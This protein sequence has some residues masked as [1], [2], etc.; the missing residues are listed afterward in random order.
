MQRQNIDIL[1]YCTCQHS[2]TMKADLLIE[3]LGEGCF[4]P[5]VADRMKCS[6]CGSKEIHSRPAYD[7]R[8]NN[9]MVPGPSKVPL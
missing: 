2:T 6:K 5:R 9:N 7:H 3:K 8:I 1:I 4:V